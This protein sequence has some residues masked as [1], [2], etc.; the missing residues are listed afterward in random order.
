MACLVK[1]AVVGDCGFGDYAEKPPPVAD[2]GAVVELV[3]PDQ[4]QTDRNQQVKLRGSGE[5]GIQT[6]QRCLQERN[7]SPQV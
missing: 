5:Q 6:A 2:G 1:L 4:R 7:R 3:L